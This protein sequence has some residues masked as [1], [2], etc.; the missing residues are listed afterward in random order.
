MTHIDR[1]G[2][3]LCI[4]PLHA[5]REHTARLAAWH[6]EA[7]SHLYAGW[8]AA[9]AHA[10]FLQERG[11]GSPPCTWVAL[12]DGK[13]CG[14]VSLVYDDLPGWSASDPWL[15]SFLVAP[16]HRRHGIGA[17]LLATALAHADAQGYPRLLLY[18]ESAAAYFARV[19]FVV[20]GSLTAGGHAV[21]VMSR[22]HPAQGAA[23]T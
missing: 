8:D 13:L 1:I 23:S 4:R 6:G 3:A 21:S 16:R 15:A 10:E 20:C 17:R 9:R 14:S 12:L 7:W 5:A 19:G 2:G 11:D 22:A 18:T